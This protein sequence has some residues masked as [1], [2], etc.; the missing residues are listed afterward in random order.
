MNKVHVV[1][2]APPL[3]S[4][5]HLWF[6]YPVANIT[7]KFWY[8]VWE[9]IKRLLSCSAQNTS[10]RTISFPIFFMPILFTEQNQR[11]SNHTT[12]KKS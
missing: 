7:I 2:I 10:Y 1:F 12:Y 8:M 3:S 9:L 11:E 6:F 5:E 4:T